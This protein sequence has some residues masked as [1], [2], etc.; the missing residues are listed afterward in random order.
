MASD[1]RV[2]FAPSPT[3]KLH[4]GGARTAIITGLS[5]VLTA[6]RSSCASTT[7][8]PPLHRRKHADHPARY[9]LAGPDWDEGPEVG[10]DFAPTPRPSARP[11]QAGRPEALGRG[12]SISLLLHQGAAR[13]RPRRAG[14]QGT[15]SGAISAVAAILIPRRPAVASRPASPHV[16]RIKVPENRGDVVI[17]DAVHGEVTFDAK[18]LDDFVI[19]RSDGTP[20]YNF[21]TVVDDA[22]MK[23]T[24]VIRGDDHLSNTP[25]QCHG[26]RGPR[27]S[28]CPMFA[29]IS[30]IPGA[31]GKKLSSATAPPRWRSTA[32][33]A[34]CPMLSSTTW[35]CSAG[36]STVRPRS[37]CAMSPPAS[38]RSTAFQEPGDLRSQEA[39][40]GQCRV[41]QWHVRC[42]VCRRD[43]GPRAARGGSHRG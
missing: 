36:R 29:H 32:T 39:R 38:S 5:P 8:I 12:Q 34:T 14:A 9:A 17:H 33:P 43:H 10:G 27:R 22:M 1:V 15:P 7:P 20:T 30:M 31:D 18:E 26:L 3:G 41:H 24:H 23:I 4:I 42:S 28:P 2:R 37:S 25:R 13:R 11:V 35:R 40:L 21:A 6:A 16:L 19:F